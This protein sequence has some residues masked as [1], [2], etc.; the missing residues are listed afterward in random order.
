MCIVGCIQN[1]HLLK[2]C[3]DFLNIRIN[4]CSEKNE[5]PSVL[6]SPNEEENEEEEREDETEEEIGKIIF[7]PCPILVLIAYIV[8]I[9][10]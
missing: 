7:K 6:D 1:L 4:L 2:I 10:I 5:K 8:L 9:Y 3:F